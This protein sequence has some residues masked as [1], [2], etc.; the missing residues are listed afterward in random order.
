MSEVVEHVNNLD[1]FLS[2][3]TRLLKASCQSF[4]LQSQ[5]S[6]TELTNPDLF[7]Y[8]RLLRTVDSLL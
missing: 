3:S 4:K 2:N 7:F 6:A 1:G 8:S 5:L